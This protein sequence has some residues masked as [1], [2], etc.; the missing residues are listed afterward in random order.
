M[1]SGW[2][3]IVAICLTWL[4]QLAFVEHVLESI[5]VMLAGHN[6]FRCSN[7]QQQPELL[8]VVMVSGELRVSMEF[9]SLSAKS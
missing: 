6:R 1:P 4:L 2:F 7:R 3:I 5:I 8:I 9:V